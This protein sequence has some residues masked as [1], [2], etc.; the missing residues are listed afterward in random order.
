MSALRTLGLMI[1]PR[2]RLL[3]WFAVVVLPFSL[4]GAVEPAAAG[5]SL[6]AIAGLLVLALADAAASR[7]SLA[8]I[9]LQLPDVARMSKD[10]EAKLEVRIRNERRR[11]KN[12][13]LALALPREIESPQE[14]AWVALP[15]DSEWSLLAWPCL[16]RRRGNYQLEARP[17][18]GGLAPRILGRAP[19]RA[20]AIRDTGLSRSIHRAA[21]PGGAVSPS[22]LFR[23]PRAAAGRQRP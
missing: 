16:P 12:L 13:R 2:N 23:P 4:L 15:P 7:T 20:R 3:L 17:S 8:G 9:S 1:I 11:P 5:I 14:D 21:E 22:R 19:A 10:R 18:G 6:A